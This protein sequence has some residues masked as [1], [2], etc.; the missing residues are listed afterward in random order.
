MTKG[1]VCRRSDRLWIDDGTCATCG[2]TVLE[3][4]LVPVLLLE[5]AGPLTGVV[6][7]RN[8]RGYD[9]DRKQK[10]GLT[11]GAAD[12]IGV[13]RGRFLAVEF[14]TAKGRQQPNQAAFQGIVERAGGIYAII[15]TLDD[16]RRLL[17]KLS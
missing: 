8:A 6:L 11:D 17:T 15:R 2:A 14:K 4:Q 16:V 9:A 5:L 1:C 3:S 10:Y 12:Y 13:C 7:W